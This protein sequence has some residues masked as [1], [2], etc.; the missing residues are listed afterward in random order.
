MKIYVKVIKSEMDVI[1]L[2]I[3][4]LYIYVWIINIWYENVVKYRKILKNK[5][6][7]MMY[8]LYFFE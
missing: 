7:I 6:L 2:V 4:I 5:F 1:L 8:V 3:G